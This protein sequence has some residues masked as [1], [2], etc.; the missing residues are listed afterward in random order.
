MKNIYSLLFF[1]YLIQTIFSATEDKSVTIEKYNG[2]IKCQYSESDGIRYG[3]SIQAISEGYTSNTKF[4]F[5]LGD[6]DYAFA[7]CTIPPSQ[8]G[9]QLIDCYISALYF[10][11][12]DTTKFTLPRNGNLQI[13]DATDD[14]H[15][16][17]LELLSE[18]EV[19]IETDCSYPYQNSF[20]V[21][22]NEPFYVIS[23]DNN[24]KIVSAL[25]SYSGN[26]NDKLKSEDDDPSISVNLAAFVDSD[27]KPITC[28]IY[29]Q[30]YSNGGED[31]IKCVIIGKKKVV[32]FPT[33]GYDGDV[34]KGYVRVSMHR[35]VSLVS[36][37]IKLTGMIFL[38]LL[39]F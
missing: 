24:T 17:G 11:L 22:P 31:E 27:Y 5:L 34:L 6:L 19:D 18:V 20:T 16:D 8:E 39:L 29:S 3:F 2:P 4:K 9:S 32:F 10:P 14:I 7:E 26:Q 23:Q 37:F 28:Y 21:G 36:S 12:F 38:S 33:M 1:A 13:F 15:F 25:G 30:E 35:E